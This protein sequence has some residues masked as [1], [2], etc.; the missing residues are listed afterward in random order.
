M[1][2]KI[3]KLSPWTIGLL[4]ALGVTIYCGLIAS[5]LLILDS[6]VGQPPKLI[7]LIFML[8]LLVFSAAVTGSLVFAYPL[9]LAVKK[10]LKQGIKVFLLTLL[11]SVLI[12]I[13]LLVVAGMV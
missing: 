8:T 5:L 10:D 12:L 11:F 2:I 7:G 6:F 9:Y 4:Q 1:A 3:E 13:S